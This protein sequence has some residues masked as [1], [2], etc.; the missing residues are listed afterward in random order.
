VQTLPVIGCFNTERLTLPQLELG[1]IDDL[2]A[3]DAD[4]DVMRYINGGRPTPPSEVE[5]TVRATSGHRWHATE[6][7]T[8]D[9]IGW[10]AL[11]PSTSGHDALE[12]GYRLRRQAW[13]RGLA[14]EG[15]A[16]LI[17]IAFETLGADRVW[18]QTMTVNT[19]SRRVLERCG[20]RYVRTFHLA[21]SEPIAGT[22]LGDLE[23][24]LLRQ[25]W[26]ATTPKRCR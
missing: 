1:D 25:D 21:W 18:A 8:S 24:E 2:V 13:G 10:F 20:L 12:L 15:A 3:L 11:D 26:R 4:P 19:P 5:A 16:A 7:S 9:F 6:R 22:E 17:A 14:T 23:Y